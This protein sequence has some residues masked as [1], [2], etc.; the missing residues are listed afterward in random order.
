MK[1]KYEIICHNERETFDKLITQ[2][3]NLGWELVG[4]LNMTFSP[5]GTPY[6]S[7]AVIKYKEC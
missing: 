1:R 3:L 7:Q 6:F 2:Y 4:N 5:T